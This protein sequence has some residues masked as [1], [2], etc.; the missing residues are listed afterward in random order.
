MK[1]SIEIAG[2]GLAGLALGI[3]LRRHGVGVTLHE[4]GHYPR[5]RVCGDFLTGLRLETLEQL[6]IGSVF[7]DVLS[8]HTVGWYR[9]GKA[10]LKTQLPEPAICISRYVLDNRLA[11]LFEDLGGELK[12]GSRVDLKAFKRT[13]GHLLA[14]GRRPAGN[15]KWSGLKIHLRGMELRDDLEVHLGDGCYTGISHVDAN[16]VNC[17]GL[18]KDL[19]RRSWQPG[20]QSLF[21]LFETAGLGDLARRCGRAEIVEGSFCSVSGLGY[22]F[23][24]K[25]DCA[26]GDTCNLIPPFTGNGMTLAF[27]SATVVL[28]ILLKYV[29]GNI[30]W[31]QCC[32]Q[33]RMQY[34]RRFQKRIWAANVLHPFIYKPIPQ[35]LIAWIAR[36]PG[37]PFSTFYSLT[38]R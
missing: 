35:S 28:P 36:G 29:T 37:I 10:V 12:R 17:C 8:A 38:H 5:H 20:K 11:K 31:E 34:R 16:T 4:A 30:S 21:D 18:F 23:R 9:R 27:E 3:G 22:G 14:T 32:E 6:G 7:E 2:G 26:V 19:H 1:H 15:R 24:G 13:E 33:M 25:G